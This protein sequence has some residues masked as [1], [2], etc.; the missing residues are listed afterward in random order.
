M[1]G[2]ERKMPS[3]Y[4]GTNVIDQFT[5]FSFKQT[6]YTSPMYFRNP[7]RKFKLSLN[8]VEVI[9][10]FVRLLRPKN[11]IE[12]GT[13]FG[14]TTV[15]VLPLIPEHYYGVDIK[16]QDNMKFLASQYKNLH[17]FEKTTDEYF[18]KDYDKRMFDMA[19]IDASHDYEQTFKDFLNIKDFIVP[20]GIIFFHDTYPSTFE[21]TKPNLSGDCYKLPEKIRLEHNDE[22]EIIT[23]PVN[24]GLSMARKVKKHIGDENDE[25]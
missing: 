1:K 20:D 6:D 8:H 2:F 12:M 10:F 19:F 14:E 3:D 9:E 16:L 11:F 15:R 18:A 22:F 7:K 25:K 24:P 4:Y 21:E 23:F 5:N 13:Q 17:L